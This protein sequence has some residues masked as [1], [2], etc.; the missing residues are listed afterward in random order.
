MILK[1]AIKALIPHGTPFRYS[2]TA[3]HEEEGY[4]A[5]EWPAGFTPPTWAE[6]QAKA[7][8]LQAEADAAQAEDE[9]LREAVPVERKVLDAMLEFF[10]EWEDQGKPLT[11]KLKK[12]VDKWR[13]L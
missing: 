6:V 4:N 2:I 8:E 1:R 11:P 9:R 3:G 10:A 5:I 12:A 13:T 7:A